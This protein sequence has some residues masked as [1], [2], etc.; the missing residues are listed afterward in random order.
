MKKLTILLLT[1]AFLLQSCGNGTGKKTQTETVKEDKAKVWLEDIFKCKTSTEGFCYYLDKEDRICSKRFMDFLIDANEI[2][3]P[4]NFTE[5]ELIEAKDRYKKKWSNIYPLYSEE[6]WLFGRG[7]DDN[8]NIMD[9]KINKIS[10][11]KYSVLIDYDGKIKTQNEVT[12]IFENNSYKI[13]YCKTKFI[14][15]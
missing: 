12:L 14:E 11:L 5:Q 10:E 2:Y 8:E 13:D 3:G 6:I 7:N 15:Q 9:V 4:S 1:T